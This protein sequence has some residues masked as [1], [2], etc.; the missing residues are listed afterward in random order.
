MIECEK[1]DEFAALDHNAIL[2]TF[3]QLYREEIGVAL[4]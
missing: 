2:S 4:T 3:R 1:A